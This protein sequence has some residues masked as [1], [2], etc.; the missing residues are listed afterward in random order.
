[1]AF[2]CSGSALDVVFPRPAI[3]LDSAPFNLPGWVGLW[4][5][6][7]FA[8]PLFPACRSLNAALPFTFLAKAAYGSGN[9]PASGGFA[10]T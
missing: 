8:A 9:W 4:N 5:G 10:F 1:M 7:T 6:L 3:L 2:T